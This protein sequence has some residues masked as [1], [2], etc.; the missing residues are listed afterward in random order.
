LVLDWLGQIVAAGRWVDLAD[1]TWIGNHPAIAHPGLATLPIALFFHDDLI[2]QRRLLLH[3]LEEN[4]V[5]QQTQTAVL[6]YTYAIAQALKNQLDPHTFPAQLTAY[7][8]LTHPSHPHPSH[9]HPAHSAQQVDWGDLASLKTLL[10]NDAGMDD[11]ELRSDPQT[12]EQAIWLALHC[13][14]A[15]PEDFVLSMTRSAQFT[16]PSSM[17]CAL[18]GALSGTYNGVVGIPPLWLATLNGLEADQESGE[19]LRSTIP[20]SQTL[21][22]WTQLTAQFLAVW[23]G[24]Y[25]LSSID[26]NPLTPSTLAVMAPWVTR[27]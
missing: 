10:M 15:T 27:R 25:D 6:A 17:V 23:A 9:P 26:S 16:H 8:R 11:A 19:T 14:L 24:M 3:I 4:P 20:R 12:H 22:S 18:V 2:K 7:L 1:E 13:F 5:H 21:Q